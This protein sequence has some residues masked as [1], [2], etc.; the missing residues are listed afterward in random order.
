[1]VAPEAASLAHILALAVERQTTVAQ[2]L[3]MP[4]YHPTLEE[5]MET[6]LHDAAAN[7]GVAYRPEALMLCDSRTE[8]PLA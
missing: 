8:E 7:L 6:A 4:F 1:M 3:Q 2:M 5:G